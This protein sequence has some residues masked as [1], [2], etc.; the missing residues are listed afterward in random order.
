MKKAQI[1]FLTLGLVGLLLFVTFSCK[2][3]FTEE[4]ALNAQQQVDLTI[5]VIDAS[6]PDSKP[7]AGV[8]VTVS[9]GSAST[10]V[11]T[12]ANGAASFPKIKVGEFVYSVTAE[13]YTTANGTNNADP[14]NFR[15]GQVTAQIGIYPLTGD[16]VA[17]IRGTA[18][19]EKDLT[20]LAPEVAN[21]VKVFAD[22]S[23]NWGT[24]TF[25]TTTDAQGN[26]ELKVPT[27]GPNGTSVNIR[28]SDFEADQI[29]VISKYAD[30]TGDFFTSPQVL[31]R[32]E[33]I[34]TVFSRSTTAQL[35]RLFDQ[36]TAPTTTATGLRSVYG[37]A[38]APSATGTLAIVNAVLTNASGEVTGV[39]FNNGGNYAGDADGKVN[40]VITS[41][42]G[43]SGASIQFTLNAATSLTDGAVTSVVTK[44]S[45]YPINMFTAGANLTLNKTNLRTPAG[46]GAGSITVFPGT[47]SISNID[48][49]SG[50]A[51]P[52]EI[53]R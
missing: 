36:N 51:R 35:N 7:V 34:K 21:G 39:T 43:G 6:T 24:K 44:G 47:V 33:T 38:D 15:Q 53:K 49:G 9:Q 41:L 40:V 19:M 27:N 28:F 11:T 23:L 2:D 20:N 22:V 31:P 17:V 12:D 46:S 16:N 4:D 45:G 52:R 25:S 14:D 30:E 1:N 5:H 50:I 26:Y 8:V 13:N 29:I 3:E 37:V 18:I 32:K 10:A 48:F 42:D